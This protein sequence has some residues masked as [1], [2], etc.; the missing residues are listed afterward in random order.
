[1]ELIRML[2][3][4]IGRWLAYVDTC[5]NAETE[6]PRCHGFWTFVAVTMGVVCVL[7][8]VSVAVRVV[9]DRRKG[10]TERGES[11]Y[12]KPS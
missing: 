2:D 7:V 3:L 6:L 5:L 12:R 9:L 4:R 10:I 1:V 11:R 8:L